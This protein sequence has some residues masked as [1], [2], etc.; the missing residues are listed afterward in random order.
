MKTCV[1]FNIINHRPENK[2]ETSKPNLTN[3]ASL[4]TSK[5]GRIGS[6]YSKIQ[7]FDVYWGLFCIEYVKRSDIIRPLNLGDK[8]AVL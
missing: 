4:F 5:S 3:F 8:F 6:F 1:L 7:S 2:T